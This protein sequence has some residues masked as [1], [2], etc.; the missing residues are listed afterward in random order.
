[1][2]IKRSK[3]GVLGGTN[4][5]PDSKQSRKKV[6]KSGCHQPDAGVKPQSMGHPVGA[7]IVKNNA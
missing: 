3:R 5:D 6:K 4:N 1:V 2:Q 7:R